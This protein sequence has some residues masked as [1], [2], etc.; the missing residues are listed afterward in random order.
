MKISAVLLTVG[1]IALAG[2]MLLVTKWPL[3]VSLFF[4]AVKI[5]TSFSL[6]LNHFFS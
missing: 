1:I 5:Y 3:I 2:N 4:T 6:F